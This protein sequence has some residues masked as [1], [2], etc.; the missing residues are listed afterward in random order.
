M[1]KIYLILMIEK[2]KYGK[3]KRNH[4]YNQKKRKKLLYLNFLHLLKDYMPLT[5]YPINNF[6]KTRIGFLIKIKIY[7]N[8]VLN[9]LSTVK[10]I[11]RIETK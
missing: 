7:I 3:K 10:I 9:Y 4:L 11:I 8:I 6:S 1:M 2:E 5:L